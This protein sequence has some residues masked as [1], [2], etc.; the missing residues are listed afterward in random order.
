VTS[1]SIRH[2]ESL[3]I[4]LQYMINNPD[5][6]LIL[7]SDMFLIDYLNLDVYRKYICACVI[8]E[9]PNLLYFWPN[10][11]YLDM[12]R[13]PNIDKLDLG[14]ITGGDTGSAS[15]KWL[16]TFNY[17]F[18]S[19]Q[20]INSLENKDCTFENYEGA[21]NKDFYFIKHLYSLSWNESKLPENI[22]KNILKLLKQDPRNQN[23]NFFYEIYDEKILHYR[24]GTN[25]MNQNKQVHY[26]NIL[27]LVEYINNL[28]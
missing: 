11:F 21:I 19:C 23:G 18:P 25:W 13:A 16:K 24:A 20:Q 9:R 1:A 26:Q 17:T 7:D 28:V 27:R 3:R 14:L 22:D 5:E 10:L 8:Q 6:Y 12:T 15:N 2:G 4:V